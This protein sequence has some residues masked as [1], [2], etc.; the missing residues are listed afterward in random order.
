MFEQLSEQTPPVQPVW[1]IASVLAYALLGLGI[2]IPYDFP[3]SAFYRGEVAFYTLA[4]VVCVS[5]TLWYHRTLPGV[6]LYAA[7][8]H[9]GIAAALGCSLMLAVAFVS[10]HFGWDIVLWNLPALRIDW[11]GGHDF[12]RMADLTAAGTVFVILGSLLAAILAPATVLLLR[13]F[14]GLVARQRA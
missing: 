14:T 2:R 5:M 7:G 6:G 13:Q 1:L 4:A 8:V 11:R 10:E 3:P 12:P 9:A